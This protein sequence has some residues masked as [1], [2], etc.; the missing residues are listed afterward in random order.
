MADLDVGRDGIVWGCDVNGM[1][2]V[3]EGITESEHSGLTWRSADNALVNNCA[4]VAVC[5]SGHVWAVTQNN[6]VYFRTGIYKNDIIGSGWEAMNPTNIQVSDVA[7]G[8]MGQVWMTDVNRKLY[9]KT[10]TE[11][12]VNPQG[13]LDPVLINSGDWASISIGENGQFFGL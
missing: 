12:A 2:V 10:G 1:P 4:R 8:G 13:D 11:D 5:T 3:R 6:E 7:C 9:T